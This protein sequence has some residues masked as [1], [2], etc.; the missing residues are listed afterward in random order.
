MSF[1]SSL[2]QAIR[3]ARLRKAARHPKGFSVRALAGRL[4]VSATWL[5]MV[6]RDLQRPSE[7]TVRTLALELDLDAAALLRLSGRVSQDVAE[8]LLAR[9]ALADAVRAMN[10][11]K[12]A[13][14]ERTVRRIRDGD[15]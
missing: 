6:E 8:M 3:D 5:S 12:D 9:P 14:I 11:L 15:W 10:A 2:G 13:E 7:E 1:T 4:G